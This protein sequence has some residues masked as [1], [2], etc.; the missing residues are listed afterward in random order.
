MMRVSDQVDQTQRRWMWTRCVLALLAFAVMVVPAQSQDELPGNDPTAWLEE[1]SVQARRISGVGDE[2]TDALQI[3]GEL[4]AFIAAQQDE[5]GLNESAEKNHRLVNL[6]IRALAHDGED[7]WIQAAKARATANGTADAQALLDKLDSSAERSAAEALARGGSV[8]PDVVSQVSPGFARQLNLVQG[9]EWIRQNAETVATRGALA[10][11]HAWVD[12]LSDPAERAWASLGVAQGL[13]AS[14]KLPERESV[15]AIVE[16]VN[17]L[18]P[19]E[20]VEESPRPVADELNAEQ[21]EENALPEVVETPSAEPAEDAALITETAEPEAIASEAA[22][23]VA[24][25]E[26]EKVAVPS[27]PKAAAEAEPVVEP[28]ETSIAS[29]ATE[30]ADVVIAPAPVP[31]V[32]VED[33]AAPSEATTTV[34]PD[35]EEVATTDEVPASTADAEPELELETADVEIEPAEASISIPAAESADVVIVPIPVPVVDV[36]EQEPAQTEPV[37]AAEAEPVVEEQPVEAEA[38]KQPV[39]EPAVAEVSQTTSPVEPAPDLAEGEAE[40][41]AVAPAVAVDEVP[42]AAEAVEG[43]AA[44]IPV[45]PN[46]KTLADPAAVLDDEPAPDE[47][48]LEFLTT[49]GSF[50]VRVHRDWAPLAADRFYDLSVSGFYHNQ[51]VFRVVEG[52]VVQWGIHGYPDVAAAWRPQTLKDEPRTQ[53]NKRGTIAFAAATQPNT[54]ATQVFI[55]LDDNQFLD[56]LG[57]APFGEIVDGL[58]VVESLFNT[59]GETPSTKQ[60]EIQLQGNAFLDT[61]YPELDSILSVQFRE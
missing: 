25:V 41:E 37:T 33:A 3:K 16:S 22:R 54:R 39:E 5:L 29:P 46:L 44:A 50:T 6:C 57:F 7:G 12:V 24:E 20:L 35:A 27:E 49:K 59:Y 19:K 17:E 58:D 30:P 26:E 47:Y 56:E 15:E 51:R 45:V 8:E 53:S 60:R 9:R 32:D 10:D 40:A 48:E 38:V 34:K 21:P 1:A 42:A 11:V 14:A 18:Q 55:N 13:I 31:V 23:P 43:A 61:V 2:L 52:F 36:E 4:L 28:A